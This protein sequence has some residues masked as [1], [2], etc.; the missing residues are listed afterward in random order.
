MYLSSK[1]SY[2]SD[3]RIKNRINLNKRFRLFK[4]NQPTFGRKIIYHDIIKLYYISV[5]HYNNDDQFIYFCNNIPSPDL[6][7]IE[8]NSFI[9]DF[10]PGRNTEYSVFPMYLKSH[11]SIPNNNNNNNIDIHALFN[12]IKQF[13]FNKHQLDIIKTNGYDTIVKNKLKINTIDVENTRGINYNLFENNNTLQHMD[14][15]RI[16]NNYTE[17]TEYTDDDDEDE[18]DDY[19][20]IIHHL[21]DMETIEYNISDDDTESD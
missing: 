21:N 3:I 7:F 15:V 5:L 12:F 9:V 1:Y 16:R 6:I 8:Y 20:E 10:I 2:E 11:K 18:D 14:T 13:N 4:N 19:D 17:E